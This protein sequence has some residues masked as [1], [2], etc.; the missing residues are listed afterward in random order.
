MYVI[1]F[2][3]ACCVVPVETKR[4][5]SNTS[6]SEETTIDDVFQSNYPES[7][8]QTPTE[9][10]GMYRYSIQVNLCY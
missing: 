5:S 4:Q 8:V 2:V 10:K 7:P 6:H 1:Y 9:Q 3:T